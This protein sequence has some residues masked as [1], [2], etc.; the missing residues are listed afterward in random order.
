MF[1]GA[2]ANE[3]LGTLAF[4]F[5]WTMISTSHGPKQQSYKCTNQLPASGGNPL[6][7]PLQTMMNSLVGYVLSIGLF[8]GLYYSNI[9]SARQFPFL[10]PLMFSE[11]ST[12]KRY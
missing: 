3:G 5:D 2:M 8:M 1:G 6:W 4:S 11:K 12:P 9:W 7:M 10:S